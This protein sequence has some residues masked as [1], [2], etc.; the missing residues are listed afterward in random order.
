[1]PDRDA[2]DAYDDERL[3]RYLVG[4]LGVEETD[5]LDELSITDDALA[6]RLRQVEDDPGGCLGER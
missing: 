2:D 4:S 1:M 3:I 6:A 5:R